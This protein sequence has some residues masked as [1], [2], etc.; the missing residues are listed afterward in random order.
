MSILC[1]LCGM[2]VN[3][4]MIKKD[5]NLTQCYDCLFSM[6]FNDKN[7]L[8]G[9]EGYNLIKYIEVSSKYHAELYDLPCHRLT[10]NGGC[11]VCMK[12]LDIPFEMPKEILKEIP[13]ETP[14]ETLKKKTKMNEFSEKE[15][16]E[17]ELN[18]KD[19][20]YY[21]TEQITLNL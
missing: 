14:S 5:N 21:L 17:T 2:K 3:E 20:D 11:Y 9:S 8:N 6:N 4:E 7:I 1:E 15:S 12:L 16:N 18:I 13:K 19:N 10:D